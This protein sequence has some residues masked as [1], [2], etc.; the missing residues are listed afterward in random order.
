MPADADQKGRSPGHAEALAKGSAGDVR[1]GAR[2]G[3]QAVRLGG[4]RAPDRLRGPQALVRE[5]RGPLAAEAEE[6]AVRPAGRQTWPGGAARPGRD[7]RRRGRG[8]EYEADA[9]RAREEARRPRPLEDVEAR[10]R[11]RHR[12]Q[13]EVAADTAA[14]DEPKTASA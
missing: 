3:A 5:G 13:T 7:V 10:A 14:G 4:A 8:G 12:P 6:G 2:R 1:E 11:P 9:L